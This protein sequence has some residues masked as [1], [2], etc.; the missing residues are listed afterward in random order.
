MITNSSTEIFVDCQGSVKPAKDLLQELLKL[1]G[2]DKSVNEVF[3]VTL[4]EDGYN[5]ETWFDYQFE[6]EDKEIYE[7]YNKEYDLKSINE[8]TGILI[9]CFIVIR[10]I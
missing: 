6:W 2:S 7:K 8:C 4:E 3:E 10:G 5:I 9:V 1:Q